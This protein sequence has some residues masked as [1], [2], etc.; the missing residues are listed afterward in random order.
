M[1][2][3]KRSVTIL[4]LSIIIFAALCQGARQCVSQAHADV[5][6]VFPESIPM[7]VGMSQWH[8]QSTALPPLPHRFSEG[9]I[10]VVRAYFEDRQQV[11][12]LLSWL[13]PWEVNEEQGYVVVGVNADELTRLEAMGFDVRLDQ[14]LSAKANQSHQ[15]LPGQSGGI[16]G[17]PCYRTV[18]ET[19]A[20]AQMLVQQYP[21]LA[22]WIDIGDSWRKLQFGESEGYDLMVLKLTNRNVNR[23]KPKLF[24]MSAVHAR[25][26]APAELTMRFAEYLVENYRKDADVTW[27]LDYQEIYLLFQANPD[28]RKFAEAGKLWRKNTNENYCSPESNYRGADLNRNF[29]FSWHACGGN[30]CSSG[31]ECAETYRGPS[32]ASEPE[33]QA[34]EGFLREIFPDQRGEAIDAPA[35]DD[36][37]GVFLDIHSYG[38]LV[39]WPW[40]FLADPVPNGAALQALGRKFAFYNGYSPEQA[41]A[42]YPTD[43]T[44][45]DFAYGELGIA[46]YTFEVG[47]WFFQDCSTFVNEIVPD[48]FP[49]LEF[50]AKA[51]RA[52]YLFPMGP[53]VVDLAVLGVGNTLTITATLDDSRFNNSNGIEPTQTITRAEYYLDVPPWDVAHHPVAHPINPKDGDFD[54]AIEDVVGVVDTSSWTGIQHTIF[55]RGQDDDG[56]WGVVSAVFTD[57]VLPELVLEKQVNTDQIPPGGQLVFTLTQSLDVTGTHAYSL[58]LTDPI[59]SAL[60]VITSS[61]KLNGEYS[62]ELYR[63]E[64][65]CIK[66]D[67]T[68]VFTDVLRFTIN[69]MA[70]SREDLDSGI[71]LRNTFQGSA[72]VDGVPIFPDT[73]AQVM[74]E[75]ISPEDFQIYLP[76]VQR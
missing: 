40:G 41:Y 32:A 16:P 8:P 76:I 36:A 69:Y 72:L 68:G 66:V 55:V 18:E 48:N 22:E 31:N 57:G 64:M 73:L 19:Y 51:S 50:A 56:N 65:N 17:F 21:H 30:D 26:Y 45:L 39:L 52:P 75:I 61:I 15:Y 37:M 53:E 49:A 34:I 6:E 1:S 70:T 74:I 13:E 33:T 28:G 3:T 12:S 38:K 4:I 7:E 44:T 62:P 2:A 27:L 5:P 71:S 29:S 63:P 10:V 60:Q 25:E 42:F 14:V 67:R 43:G 9:D 24:V 47:S 11:Y 54:E 23:V 35:P 58:T 20:S 46:T 59:T